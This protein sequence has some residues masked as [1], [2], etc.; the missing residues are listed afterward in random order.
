MAS[1]QGSEVAHPL[2]SFLRLMSE[3]A[4]HI[5]SIFQ[6]II[7]LCPDGPDSNSTDRALYD[8]SREWHTK[9]LE[10]TLN[11]VSSVRKSGNYIQELIQN[12]T[13]HIHKEDLKS[14]VKTLDVIIYEIQGLSRCTTESVVFFNS[15]KGKDIFHSIPKILL[16]FKL[17]G[18]KRRIE[19]FETLY[20]E[21]A[22]VMKTATGDRSIELMEVCSQFQKEISRLKLDIESTRQLLSNFADME[23]DTEELVKSIEGVLENIES[24]TDYFKAIKLLLETKDSK[25]TLRRLISAFQE[26]NLFAKEA[27]KLETDFRLDLVR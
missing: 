25:D 3:L 24:K 21:K 15:V 8:L 16:D 5:K 1:H 2:V 18:D 6:N 14:A 22:E 11:I 19:Y 26:W 13:D 9:Y 23:R 10:K 20:A 17:P 4:K 27:A 12:S 7:D